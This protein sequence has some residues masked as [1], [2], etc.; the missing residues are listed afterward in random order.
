MRERPVPPA[1]R[2]SFATP[3]RPTRR[4]R[5]HVGT[6][7]ATFAS[8]RRVWRA[9]AQGAPNARRDSPGEAAVRSATQPCNAD[10][11]SGQSGSRR[12]LCHGGLFRALQ[13]E[14]PVDDKQWLT[15]WLL[16]TVFEVGVSVLD[17]LAVYVVPFY[18]E[19]KVSLLRSCKPPIKSNN[20]QYLFFRRFASPSLDSYSSLASLAEQDSSTPCWSPFSSKPTRLPGSTRLSPRRRS[21][22]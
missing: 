14:S 22:S 19:I 3:S 12:E 15:F 2:A 9:S 21:T 7:A 1:R 4:A 6:S 10:R 8:R 18:G 13:S 5:R 17:I 11:S 20:D 16:F